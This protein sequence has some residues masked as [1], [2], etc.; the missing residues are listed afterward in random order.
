MSLVYNDILQSVKAWIEKVHPRIPVILDRPNE[1]RPRRND[2]KGLR[3][4]KRKP[5]FSISFVTPLTRIGGRDSLMDKPGEGNEETFVLGG[6]RTFT[7]GIMV[8]SDPSDKNFLQG[9]DLMSALADSQDDPNLREPL[10]DS[11]LAIFIANDILDVTDSIESGFEPRVSMDVIMG[12]ASNR[13]TKLGA[14][15][16]TEITGTLNGKEEPPFTVGE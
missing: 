11:G 15:D 3:R 14:I 9:H 1:P 4:S 2:G 7:V 5:Y 6:Q 13:D 8:Y 12:V 16:K 10:T